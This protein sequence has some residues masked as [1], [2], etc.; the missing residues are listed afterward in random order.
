MVKALIS[1]KF[2]QKREFFVLLF[3][4]YFDK[5][6][7]TTSL[8]SQI[9][10][11]ASIF[12]N[13]EISVY[14]PEMISTV[15]QPY[16]SIQLVCIQNM[17]TRFYTVSWFLVCIYLHLFHAYVRYPAALWHNDLMPPSD[18]KVTAG[19]HFPGMDD[20]WPHY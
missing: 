18:D 20:L 2:S 5:Q 15:Q 14:F 8:N 6:K 16:T 17:Y 1:Q 10:L 4:S 12:G 19:G 13:F 11:F 3:I 7:W 9:N